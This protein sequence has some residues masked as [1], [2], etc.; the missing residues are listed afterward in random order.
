M[1]YYS[2]N[3][4]GG[5][6]TKQGAKKNPW[7]YF[8]S[9]NKGS[10]I[11][12]EQLS[13]N[14]KE[15]KKTQEFKYFEEN[16]KT[17]IPKTKIPKTKIPK[18]KIPKQREE[19]KQ[20]FV[21]KENIFGFNQIEGTPYLIGKN[22]DVVVFGKL[23]TDKTIKLLNDK[24]KEYI[25]SIGLKYRNVPNKSWLEGETVMKYFNQKYDRIQE[26][27]EEEEKESLKRKKY[28]QENKEDAEEDEDEE[29]TPQFEP[30]FEEKRLIPIKITE[31]VPRNIYDVF[32]NSNV[33]TDFPTI[34]RNIYNDSIKKQKINRPKMILPPQ[35]QKQKKCEKGDIYRISYLVCNKNGK[36]ELTGWKTT[37]GSKNV[38]KTKNSELENC[39]KGNIYKISYIVCN[40]NGKEELDGWKKKFG[41]KNVVKVSNVE[42]DFKI[43]NTT[44][45]MDSWLENI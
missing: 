31:S 29:S 25:T 37:F 10:G 45:N 44:F 32:R 7:L 42:K 21:I 30:V 1:K 34:P 19:N 20:N 2:E 35:T 40:R 39:E 24:D 43:S 15:W 14:Y 38:V 41:T 8:L 5:L 11:K 33:K 9:I 12:R 17:K 18:T 4:F 22:G 16:T 13:K 27:E 6:G 36:E 26:I 23:F 28:R 3:V